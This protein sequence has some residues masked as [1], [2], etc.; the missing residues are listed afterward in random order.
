MASA[1]TTK[2]TAISKVWA[3]GAYVHWKHGPN[4][5]HITSNYNK[6]KAVVVG[7]GKIPWHE[8]NT[9]FS[10]CCS[11]N[12]NS[13]G[14]RAVSSKVLLFI[15]SMEVPICTIIPTAVFAFFHPTWSPCPPPPLRHPRTHQ[16]PHKCF[17]GVFLR[18]D[19]KLLLD[20]MF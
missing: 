8:K 9:R 1:N 19:H 17:T 7:Q 18:P 6:G 14:I 16:D 20:G 5:K 15:I 2:I 11:I 12:P 13:K 4:S 3:T 10:C